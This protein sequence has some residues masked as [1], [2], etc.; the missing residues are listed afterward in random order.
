MSESPTRTITAPPPDAFHFGR[1]WQRYLDTAFSPERLAVAEQSLKDLIGVESLAGLSWLDI[2]C[3]SGIF[4]LAARRLGAARLTSVDIDP[5][6]VACCKRLREKEGSPEN[7][8]VLHG[9]VLDPGFVAGIEPADVV[10]SWGVLHH[11]GD[12]WR[13]IENAASRVRPGGRFVIAIYNTVDGALGSKTWLRIKRVYVKSPRW[14]Q[15]IMTRG[16]FL[17]YL[18]SLG[19]HGRNP[20]RAVREYKQGRGMSVLT[21]VIDWVGGYPYEFAT[22]AEII[23]FC[24][25]RLGMT[26]EN[27]VRVTSL[28]NN[29][30]TFRAP[31]QGAAA[32]LRSGGS[33]AA[34]EA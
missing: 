29:E 31:A 25:R 8:R 22:D 16:Y 5:D 26:L 1:N 24:Q 21:D 10:Y 15:W 2:G 33:N 11:T 9:S 3:G 20:I 4:S 32:Q 34:P 14:F 6:A 27:V 12:M 28:A 19:A 23:D 13:A 17:Y 18:L 30:F 7:W